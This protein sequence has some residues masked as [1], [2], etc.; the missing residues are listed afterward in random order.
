MKNLKDKY[1]APA[2]LKKLIIIFLVPIFLVF[3]AGCATAKD[4]F[5]FSEVERVV[6]LGDLHGDFKAYEEIMLAAGLRSLKGKWIGGRTHLVQT[7][8]ITDRGPDS[9]KIYDDLFKLAKKAKKKGGQIHLL[10]GNHEMMNI[11]GDLRYVTAGE[12]AAF[13]TKNSEKNLKSFFDQL[14]SKGV[15]ATEM[16]EKELTEEEVY[17]NWLK[18]HPEGFYEHRLA[19]GL[20]GEYYKKIIQF[21]S[22]VKINGVLF[23]HAGISPAYAAVS[24]EDFNT[25]VK[26]A[27]EKNDEATFDMLFAEDAPLW[28]RGLAENG[29]EEIPNLGAVLENFGAEMI[30]LGHT[31]TGGI[32]L[33][34]LMGRVILN[35][36]GLADYYGGSRAFLLYEDGAW[37][38]V[39]WGQKIKLPVPGDQALIEYLKKVAALNPNPAYIEQLIKTLENPPL[40]VVLN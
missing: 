19:W 11:M 4:G 32:V 23:T 31:P 36:V 18:T 29:D 22:L 15:F 3:L 16:T 7:G 2:P 12:Y 24:L 5:V 13:R 28:Y 20:G 14:M 6:A 9:K 27:I 25:L 17:E 35:D 1:L 8:D 30:V 40:E 37:F 10:I 26:Q 34:R 38:G 39:H 21:P 33:P